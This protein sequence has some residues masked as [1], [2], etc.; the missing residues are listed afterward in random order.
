MST[1]DNCSCD[2]VKETIR[3][4]VINPFH[5]QHRV[6]VKPYVIG[7]HTTFLLKSENIVFQSVQT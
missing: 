6:N 3:P 5:G 7:C 1:H 4:Q 2:E